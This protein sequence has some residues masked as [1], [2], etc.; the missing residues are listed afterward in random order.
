MLNILCRQNGDIM[1]LY[2]SGD[3]NIDSSNFIEAV[4]YHLE[5]GI[6]DFLCD[7]SEVNLVDYSGLSVLAIAFKNV[8][9]HHGRIKFVNVAAHIKS[10]LSLVC[11]DKV[12]EIYPAEQAALNSFHEDKAIDEIKKMKLRRKFK[13]LPIVVPVEFKM[14]G[15]RDDAFHTGKVHNLSAIGAY[16]FSKKIYSLGDIL[17]MRIYLNPKPGLLMFEGKVVWVAHK[18]LMPQVSPGMGVEF[19]NIS[20]EIQGKI[21]EFV[22]RNLPLEASKE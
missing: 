18:E 17:T 3:I 2:L 15:S 19:H 8:L 14:K 1:V 16:I 5:S 10:I 11:L 13:R 22:E 21:V 20:I 7:F 4:G 9:N 12:F 6:T